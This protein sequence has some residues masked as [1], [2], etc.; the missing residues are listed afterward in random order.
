MTRILFAE[1]RR[2]MPLLL[3]HIHEL[4]ERYLLHRPVPTLAVVGA[5]NAGK[6][7][8]INALLQ[9]EISPVDILPATPCPLFFS[10]GETFSVY[11]DGRFK[12]SQSGQALFSL[13]RQ[14]NIRVNRVEITLPNPWLKKCTLIDTPGLDTANQNRLLEKIVPAADFILYLFHQRGPDEQ[15]RY[16]LYRL[17]GSPFLHSFNRISFWVNSNCGHPD[18]SALVAARTAVGEIFGGEVPVNYLNTKNKES[19]EN[20]RLFMEAELAS[21]AL[22]ELE[23]LFKEEDKH[24]PRQL[25]RTLSIKE[26]GLFLNMFWDIHERARTALE[27]GQL[28]AILQQMRSESR[29]RLAAYNQKVLPAPLPP[30]VRRETW[31]AVNFSLIKER[32]LNLL[33]RLLKDPALQSLPTREHLREL[34]KSMANDRF[35]ITLWGPFSSGKSTFLNALMQEV[36]L[37]AQD[38]S[39]TS[40]LVRLNHGPEKLAV[41]HYPL[42]ATLFLLDERDGEVFLCRE[43]LVTLNRWLNNP[44]FLKNLREIEVYTGGK[45]LR[46][47]IAELSTLLAQTQNLFRPRTFPAG[48]NSHIP[49]ITRSIPAKRAIRAVTAVRLSFYHAREKTFRL[50]DPGELAEFKH[51]TVTPEEAMLVDGIDIYHPAEM[52]KLATFID[53]PGIDSVHTRYA[54]TVAG[55]LNKSDVHLVFFNGRHMLSPAHRDFLR[56]TAFPEKLREN[57]FCVINFADTLNRNEKERMAAFLRRE[58]APPAPLEIHFISALDALRDKHNFAFNQFLRR[59]EWFILTQRG[60]KVLLR[61][62]EQIKELLTMEGYESS[63][64]GRVLE[65]YCRELEEI[66]QILKQPGGYRLWKMPAS[67]RKG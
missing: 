1:H 65:K 42:Q 49:A 44:Q 14:K 30:A 15:D 56:H 62:I 13:L 57:C 46:V 25:A 32:L 38:K 7:T 58:L 2:Q 41:A 67:L 52:F 37:P 5:C 55:W 31:Q 43:E 47:N 39:T 21:L 3:N 29:E 9:E 16:F 35:F 45:F 28:S 6:S 22:K 4:R 18:G 36:L 8:L 50:A 40:S 33:Q 10:Y 53:T 54:K 23:K 60:E 63:P 12:H 64:T 27:T 61:R 51:L 17:K 24:I 19:V 34:A 11:A 20:L 26:D 48:I 66:R 59:L